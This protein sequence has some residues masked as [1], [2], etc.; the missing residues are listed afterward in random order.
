MNSNIEDSLKYTERN[1]QNF[2]SSHQVMDMGSKANR[3]FDL[4]RDLENQ[5]A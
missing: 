5:K 1:L 2:R 3:I 4:T